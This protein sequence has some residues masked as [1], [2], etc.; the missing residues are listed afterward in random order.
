M[1]ELENIKLS[2]I[3]SEDF[4]DTLH[5]IEKSFCLELEFNSFEKAKTFGDICDV[6]QNKI[7]GIDKPDCTSQQTFL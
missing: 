2:E 7:S 3:D 5:K 1:K 6:F 4:G